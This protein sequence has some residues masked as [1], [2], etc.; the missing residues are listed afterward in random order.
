MAVEARL[1]KRPLNVLLWFSGYCRNMR[2]PLRPPVA[3]G[4]LDNCTAA[5]PATSPRPVTPDPVAP[6]P[7][8]LDTLTGKCIRAQRCDAYFRTTMVYILGPLWCIFKDHYGVYLRTTMVYI[9]RHST[10]CLATRW[11][12]TYTADWV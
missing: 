3:V 8:R 12:V 1:V 10:S 2:Y 9:L 11:R 4:N 5:P 6:G 7:R